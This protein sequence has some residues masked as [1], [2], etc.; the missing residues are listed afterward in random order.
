MFEQDIHALTETFGSELIALRRD[1]HRHAERGWLEIRT[2]SKV[3]KLLRQAGLF[4]RL[5][6]EVLNPEARMGLPAQEEFDEHVARALEQGAAQEDLAVLK[7][8]LTAVVGELDTGR[9]GPTVGLRVDLDANDGIESSTAASHRPAREGF[10][11]INRGSH[12]NCGH[13]GHTAIAVAVAGILAALK[14]RLRGR[15]KFLFQP[16]EEGTRGAKAMVESD[17]VDDVEKLLCFHIGVGAQVT[18]QIIAGTYGFHATTK[19]N[20]RYLGRAAH[21]G[22]V[23]EQGKNALLA[24][25]TAVLN[26][27]AL[28]RHSQGDSR[29]NVGFLQAGH[30]R[31]IIP[32]EAFLRA[33]TR[34]T[35]N[36]V[37][38]FLAAYA[39]RI[40]EQAGAMHD[41][42]CE[43]TIVGQAP[44]A[45]SDEAL[46][47]EVKRAASAVNGVTRID[48]AA[49]FGAADDATFF[50]LRVQSR[51]GQACYVVFGSDL[52][53]GHHTPTFDFDERT[54]TIAT[55][56]TALTLGRWMGGNYVANSL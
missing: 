36:E 39:R 40:L 13:D 22:H 27:L 19:L 11:S 46:I 15:C 9:A 52:A 32:A 12:H 34:G 31:N 55:E 14:D 45:S 47:Q 54:L 3:A 18:G 6:R 48:D 28:P 53:A 25:A 1:L 41:V 20:A 17:V 5:G 26:L 35:T 51:G 7:D 42:A 30:G 24:A 21:A 37:D 33:E 8:G 23:P 10:A 2:A 29:I 43:V 16:A 49:P 4:V 50:M 56:V 38:A 44:T